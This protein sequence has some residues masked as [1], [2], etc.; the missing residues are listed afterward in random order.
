MPN[1]LQ[2]LANW[3]SSVAG[4][5]SNLMIALN[6]ATDDLP[7]FLWHA[8]QDFS[9][10]GLRNAAALSYYAIFS[11]FPMLLLVVVVL[12]RVLGQVLTEEQV[13]SALTPFLPEGATG[14]LTL[15][16]SF[17][18]GAF[19]LSGSVTVIAI[20]SLAWAGLGLFGNIASGL[21]T[22]FQAERPIGLVRGRIRAL[23][24]AVV[25]IVLLSLSFLSSLVIGLFDSLTLSPAGWLRIST[26]ALPLG[27]NMLIFT[28]LF[29]FVPGR[30]PEWEAIWPA[31]LLGALLWEI[32]KSLFGL[33]TASSLLYQPVF[34]AIASG[35]LLLFWIYI[36]AGSFLFSAEIC[37]HLDRWLRE[38]R[39]QAEAGS[40]LEAPALQAGPPA[41]LPPDSRA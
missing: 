38:R 24:M 19:E 5:L 13:M 22:I 40:V 37:A 31:A 26:I 25:L 1:P 10:R 20:L 30:R 6:R 8:V 7:R 2:R 18:S 21:D 33:L 23:V 41:E 14:A 32:A 34:G 9:A 35:M 16:H 3:L 27:L 17:V 28:L 4:W 39:W 15:I 12:S 29:R 36:L 11:V